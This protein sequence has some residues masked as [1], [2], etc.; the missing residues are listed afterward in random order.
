MN[1]PENRVILDLTSFPTS[2][3]D[4]GDNV[5]KPPEKKAPKGRRNYKIEQRCNQSSLD[6][7]TQPGN[8]ETDKRGNKIIG[9]FSHHLKNSDT[10]GISVL[11]TWPDLSRRNQLLAGSLTRSEAIGA[12]VKLTSGGKQVAN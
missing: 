5:A 3:V 12:R 2:S 9:G 11:F 6:Q 8:E 7:L 10:G 1:L 4:T